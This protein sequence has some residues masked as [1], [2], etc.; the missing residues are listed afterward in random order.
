MPVRHLPPKESAHDMA[1]RR[2]NEPRWV[3]LAYLISSLVAGLLLA[4]ATQAAPP[5]KYEKK[6]K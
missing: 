4:V 1:A 3:G 2:M 6:G 5:A